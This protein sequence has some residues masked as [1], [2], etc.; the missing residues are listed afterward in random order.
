M[1]SLGSLCCG[2]RVCSVA[3]MCLSMTH[4]R[5]CCCS[6]ALNA[7]SKSTACEVFYLCFYWD[8]NKWYLLNIVTNGATCFRLSSS[9]ILVVSRLYLQ[10]QNK[11]IKVTEKLILHIQWEFC[12]N[13]LDYT[14]TIHT[15]WIHVCNCQW[16]WASTT[17]RPRQ[18]RYP[19]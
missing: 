7:T 3:W 14:H 2:C 18:W 10:W 6:S 11:H 5:C 12:K 19:G 1:F 8:W 4:C 16:D 13:S 9:C 15:H 17:A